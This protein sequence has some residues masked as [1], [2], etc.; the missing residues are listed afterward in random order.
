MSTYYPILTNLPLNLPIGIIVSK[1]DIKKK[2]KEVKLDI[3]IFLKYHPI[4]DINYYFSSNELLQIFKLDQFIKNKND[5]K[6]NTSKKITCIGRQPFF[7]ECLFQNNI[8]TK[9]DNTFIHMN[10]FKDSRERDFKD[11]EHHLS[12]T[13]YFISKYNEIID[14]IIFEDS[15]Y[16]LLDIKTPKQSLIHVHYYRFDSQLTNGAN[17]FMQFYY[18]TF[19]IY[20]LKNLENNGTFIIYNILFTKKIIMDLYVITKEFLKKHQFTNQKYM[21]EKHC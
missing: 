7:F 16:K 20:A 11:L 2:E 3:K 18:I 1:K 15:I 12:Q 14:V 9:T 21:K 13:D 6:S 8:A 5:S 19:F 17:S 10:K 4:F